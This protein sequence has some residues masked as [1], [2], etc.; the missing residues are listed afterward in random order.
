[1]NFGTTFL[2]DKKFLIAA[3]TFGGAIVSVEKS[4]LKKDSTI[5]VDGELATCWSAYNKCLDRGYLMDAGRTNVTV[6]D[7]ATGKELPSIIAST[8][9]NNGT[10]GGLY[11]TTILDNYS[12]SLADPNGV[13]VLDL[14]TEKQAQYFDLMPYGARINFEGM[15]SWP[16]S[17]C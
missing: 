10:E 13:V 7:I 4:K 14:K 8:P 1:M 17:I 2:S 12:Y 3:P 9:G 16:S 5:K 15:A 11:D 6:I